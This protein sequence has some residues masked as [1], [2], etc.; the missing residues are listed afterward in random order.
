MGNTGRGVRQSACGR[1]FEELNVR[2]LAGERI[3]WC[4]MDFS[5]VIGSQ[6]V[7]EYASKGDGVI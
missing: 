3:D 2:F 7:V 4:A 6:Q 1:S 5:D